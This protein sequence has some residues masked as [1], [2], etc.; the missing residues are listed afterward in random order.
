MPVERYPCVVSQH[1]Q[2]THYSAQAQSGVNGQ[3]AFCA[4]HHGAPLISVID[5][6]QELALRTGVSETGEVERTFQLVGMTKE[7]R[8]PLSRT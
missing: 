8:N 1:T 7:S 5:S 3:L 6:G 4:R 2:L